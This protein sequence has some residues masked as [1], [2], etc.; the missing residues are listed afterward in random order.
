MSVDSITKDAISPEQ[1]LAC[2]REGTYASSS[3]QG[4]RCSVEG[5]ACKYRESDQCNKW[6]LKTNVEML[7]AYQL[8]AIGKEDIDNPR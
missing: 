8:A 3:P 2:Q 1:I 5:A 6:R 7:K 4:I